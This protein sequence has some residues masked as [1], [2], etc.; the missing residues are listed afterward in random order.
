MILRALR[1]L[2]ILC[3]AGFFEL[4][5]RPIKPHR[6]MEPRRRLNQKEHASYIYSGS[7]QIG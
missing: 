6:K 4:L 7:L 3:W 2:I 5:K 1:L